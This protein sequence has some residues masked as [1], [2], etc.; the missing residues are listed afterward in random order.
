MVILG[1]DPGLRGGFAL[2]RADGKT[3]LKVWDANTVVHGKKNHLDAVALAMQL[4]M[5]PKIDFAVVEDVSAM[6]YTDARGELRG[7]GA[8]ASFSFGRS[9][10]VI[11]GV[12]AAM[13]IQIRKVKPAI[14]KSILGLSASKT[15]ARKLAAKLFPQ[16]AEL[17]KRAKDD[18][19][20]EA[21]LLA[22]F[23]ADRFV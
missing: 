12:L 6:T 22:W 2:L 5:C 1:V 23:G 7:Q 15:E 4:E 11:D 8:A 17:F 16:S 21:C 9:A 20:A 18:G 10:G 13:G 3:L 19:R 14:W